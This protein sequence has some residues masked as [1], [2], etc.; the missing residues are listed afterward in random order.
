MYFEKLSELDKS[1][2]E[3]YIKA[4]AYHSTTEEMAPLQDILKPWDEA[5]SGYLSTLF[6]DKLIIT[7]PIQFQ[8]GESELFD[9]VEDILYADYRCDKFIDEIK[10]AYKCYRDLEWND[11]H[12]AIWQAVAQ[13]FTVDVLAKNS[14]D[15]SCTIP[16]KDTMYKIQK[17]AK[18]IRVITKIANAYDI[19]LMPDENGISD[20]E[21]FRRVHSQVLNNKMLY[22]DLCLSIHPLD[23]MTMSD[24]DC[25]WGSCMS[26]ENDGE[27]KQGTV[28]MMNSPCVVVGYLTSSSTYRFGCNINDEWNSKKWRCLFI[29]DKDFIINIKGYPYENSNLVKAA[30][31]ELAKLAGWGKIEP[32]KYEYYEKHEEYRHTKTP[33]SING[34]AVAIDFRTQAMYN[35]FRYGHY[36]ALNPS[37]TKDII[38]FNYNYSGVS[39]CVWCGNTNEGQI[40]INYNTEALCCSN[41]DETYCC[42]CCNE[43]FHGSDSYYTTE[44][45]CRICEYCWEECTERDI[46]NDSYYLR[47]NMNAIRLNDTSGKY[48]GYTYEF[49]IYPDNINSKGWNELFKIAEPREECV[50]S[51]YKSTIYYVLPQDC[52]R[53]ALEL[54]GLD[55]DEIEEY[56]GLEQTN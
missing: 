17:G 6:K 11:P 32:I 20:L 16:I 29:V 10:R 1:R 27:Y 30:I 2:I 50:G 9:K 56:L 21:H 55:Q 8:E 35:D 48:E 26:W 4:Y 39:E 42:D 51:I 13:L 14:V 46:T 37:E 38:D 18:P 31:V 15:Y 25:G 36:I 22:G 23:Y 49:Y 52:T 12:R 47:E 3:N 19:G 41:C 24:N 43:T 44:E 7:K 53:E 33:C 40:G 54:I 34:R 28:E 45:G 5:K